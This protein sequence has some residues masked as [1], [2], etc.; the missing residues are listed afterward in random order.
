MKKLV[1]KTCIITILIILSVSF[2]I[3]CLLGLFN[4]SFIANTAFRLNLKDVCVT[5]TEKQYLKTESFDD[6]ITLTERS[7]WAS[8]YETTAEYSAILLNHKDFESFSA[9]NENY[10]NY[11]A[12]SL[13]EALQKT[14]NTEKAIET[15]FAY[16]SGESKPNPVRILILNA[17]DDND[18]LN[19]VLKKLRALE[20]KT[21]ETKYLINQINKLKGE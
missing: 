6:L 15:A 20:N 5:Y 3:I 2:L 19:A 4:P 14:G 13:V 10:E 16:Y 8:S 9:S 11:V 12:S 17:I 7:V 18:T 21:E 1:I